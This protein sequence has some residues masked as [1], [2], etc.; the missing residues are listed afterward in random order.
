M[1]NKTGVLVKE[2]M[3]RKFPILDSSM[4]LMR[5][6]KKMNKKHEACL[7]I[8]KGYFYGVLG[9]N[10][11][12]RSFMY[13]KDKYAS[14]DEIKI[15]KNFAVVKPDSDIYKTILLMK[16]NDI[17]FIVVK[18]RGSFLGL[19]TKKEIVNVEPELFDNLEK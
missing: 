6:V 18:D 4:P 1:E 14:I 19:V 7:I 2:V 3:N 13:G 8:K 16:R 9:F 17:D 15:R 12:L 10:D 11:I 5:C